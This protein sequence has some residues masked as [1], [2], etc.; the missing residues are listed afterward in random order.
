[1][2]DLERVDGVFRLED[3][4]GEEIAVDASSMASATSPSR[5]ECPFLPRATG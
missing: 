4:D 2:I 1:V 3:V 5:S